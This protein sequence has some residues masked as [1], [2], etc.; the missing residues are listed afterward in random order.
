MAFGKGRHL[1]TEV[2]QD[3]FGWQQGHLPRSY[4]LVVR[5]GCQHSERANVVTAI[6]QS[7]LW[8]P[9]SNR[10]AWR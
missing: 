6:L 7:A 3:S 5:E 1:A 8:D 4:D 2:M 9:E 10:W